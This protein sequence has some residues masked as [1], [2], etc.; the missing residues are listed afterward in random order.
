MSFEGAFLGQIMLPNGATVLEYI[1]QEKPLAIAPP[2]RGDRAM[3]GYLSKHNF[4]APLDCV[5]HIQHNAHDDTWTVRSQN[6]RRLLTIRM[7]QPPPDISRR[8]LIND[9]A[10]MARRHYAQGGETNFDKGSVIF[11]INFAIDKWGGAPGTKTGGMPD[12][13][14]M[15]PICG[16]RGG[17]TTV[18]ARTDRHHG[19]P[20]PLPCH[21]RARRQ[22]LRAW[23]VR[24]LAPR[25]AAGAISR[26]RS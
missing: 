8:Q 6:A 16:D 18:A 17:Q 21:G 25:P 1:E 23:T 7:L 26:C 11:V 9:L 22:G 19:R 3:T 5:D 14:S 10:D 15:N 2:P 12:N 4:I 24:R 13:A 20:W